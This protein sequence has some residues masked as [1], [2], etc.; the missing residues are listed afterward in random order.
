MRVDKEQSAAAAAA[1]ASHRSSGLE[2][3]GV[4][5]GAMEGDER[6][7]PT[8]GLAHSRARTPYSTGFLFTVQP[9]DNKK[10]H[11]RASNEKMYGQTRAQLLKKIKDAKGGVKSNPRAVDMAL[12][13]RNKA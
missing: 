9:D 1:I 6:S 2:A 3:A 5:A 10:V 4:G 11:R 13:G 7:A 8:D 12:T